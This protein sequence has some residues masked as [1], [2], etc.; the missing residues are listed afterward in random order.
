MNS[1][2]ENS[3]LSQS[4]LEQLVCIDL[5]E[6]FK[7]RNS[8][9]AFDTLLTFNFFVKSEPLSPLSSRNYHG[10]FRRL[11]DFQNHFHS[12]RKPFFGIFSNFHDVKIS[13][14]AFHNHFTKQF[15]IV[16][17]QTKPFSRFSSTFQ[18]NEWWN[19]DNFLFI[20]KQFTF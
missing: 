16:H 1:S 20:F 18:D 19:E 3:N 13:L 12:Q 7:V 2:H 11:E 5:T 9:S 6:F 17:S 15:G 10:N 8:Q 4:I 14:G